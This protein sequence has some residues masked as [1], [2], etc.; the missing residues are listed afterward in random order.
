MRLERFV[1]RQF[2]NLNS[3]ELAC[4]PKLNVLIGHNAQGKTNIIEGLHVLSTLSSFRHATTTQLIQ[5]GFEES[6]LEGRV[7]VDNK[8]DKFH[9]LRVRLAGV[10][11]SCSVDDKIVD[12]GRYTT[13]LKAVVFSPESLMAIKTGPEARRDLL[14]EA[15]AQVSSS[16]VQ[17]RWEFTKTLKQRNALLKQL[18]NEL[19]SLNYA[20]EMLETLD[21]FYIDASSRLTW[22]RQNILLALQ[23]IALET[24]AQILGEPDTALLIEYTDSQESWFNAVSLDQ[25]KQRFL[26]AVSD[27]KRRRA[28]EALGTTLTGPHRHDVRF[29][30]NGKDS[31]IFASQ[32]QQRA[33]ILAFKIAEIVYHGSTFGSFPILLLD[34]VLSELD[35]K[36]R[37]YLIEFLR[38][39][40]A[41]TFVTTT[42]LESAELLNRESHCAV[43][44]VEQGKVSKQKHGDH[45]GKG[46]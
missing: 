25:V 35:E 3:V 45:R 14:D 9:D 13:Y 40:E 20:R 4:E 29:V 15:L 5:E 17:A 22:E 16:A 37:N 10:R 19:I 18:K 11:R 26:V 30:F 42:D 2:R 6:Q 23:P 27:E 12:P 44:R 38:S 41:Q 39:N 1:A 32:G 8:V 31:R 46:E 33:L 43:F 34:D 24:L 28:E 21:L 7:Y 36:K